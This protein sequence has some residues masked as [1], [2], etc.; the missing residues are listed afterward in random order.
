MEARKITIISTKNN[1]K[2]VISSTATTLGEL[3]N[4][5]REVNINYKDM[6]FYE[7]LTKTELKSDASLL[8][9]NVER[10]NPTTR[11]PEVTNELVFMLTNT[12]KKIKSGASRRAAA[13]EYIKSHNLQNLVLTRFRKNFTLCSTEALEAVIAE[14]EQAAAQSCDCPTPVNTE[15]HFVDKAERTALVMLVE[16]LECG[17]V[18]TSSIANNIKATLGYIAPKEECPYSDDEIENMFSDIK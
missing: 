17:E 10:I 14:N 5:L 11:E 8:P 1:K 6:A 3:K 12:Q 9:Q 18:I 7:G 16:A 2:T 4:D 13:Y 15:E